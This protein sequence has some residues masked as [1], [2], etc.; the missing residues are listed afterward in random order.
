MGRGYRKK[1]P[2]VQPVIKAE[3]NESHFKL[4]LVLAIAFGLLAAGMIVY[5]IVSLLRADPGWQ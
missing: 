5:G 1:E 4:R 2:P 3:L